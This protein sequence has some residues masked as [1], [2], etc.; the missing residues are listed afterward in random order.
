MQLQSSCTN[1]ND[2]NALCR[3]KI[4]H[5]TDGENK[6]DSRSRVSQIYFTQWTMGNRIILDYNLDI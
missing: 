4:I 6:S 5:S 2:D 1:T 3:C